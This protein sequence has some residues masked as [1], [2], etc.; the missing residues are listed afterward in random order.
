MKRY[1]IIAL[2]IYALAGCKNDPEP[3][4]AEEAAASTQSSDEA[5]GFQES[6]PSNNETTV[7]PTVPAGKLAPQDT[8]DIEDS[9]TK[10][11]TGTDDINNDD[12][13]V[14][15]VRNGHLYS[16]HDKYHQVTCWYMRNDN[17]DWALSCLPDSQVANVKE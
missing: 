11:Q 6:A 3:N 14:T 13:P 7:V 16:T 5:F 4:A 9:N 1:I 2:A 15:W 12:T 10:L 8:D 17:G